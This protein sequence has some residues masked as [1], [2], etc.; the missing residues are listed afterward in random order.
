LSCRD[1]QHEGRT[2]DE[3][4]YITRNDT[5]V[6]DGSNNF[7]QLV[8]D[9]R[10]LTS[11][12]SGP[13]RGFRHRSFGNSRMKLSGTV[14]CVEKCK[15]CI[16]MISFNHSINRYRIVKERERI[17][18]ETQRH[19]SSSSTVLSDKTARRDPERTLTPECSRQ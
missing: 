1:A 16:I 10:Y 11:T 5:T 3:S 19:L 15:Q 8:E 17:E 14:L 13:V 12:P 7:R 9:C 18:Q 6:S 4:T 2:S